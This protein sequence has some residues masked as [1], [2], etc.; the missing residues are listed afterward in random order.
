MKFC[1]IVIDILVIFTS[2][3]SM[4]KLLVT[5]HKRIKSESA[6]L[7]H[8]EQ[9]S[10]H[11]AHLELLQGRTVLL[12]PFCK[13]L[14]EVLSLVAFVLTYRLQSCSP[15]IAHQRLPALKLENDK[16]NVIQPAN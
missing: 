4:R 7:H 2:F 13:S 12:E 9:H 8:S 10:L 1:Q 3:F 15:P 14:S 16:I 5:Y 11:E 6:L